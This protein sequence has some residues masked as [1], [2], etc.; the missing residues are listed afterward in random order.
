MWTLEKCKDVNKKFR[1]INSSTNS[2]SDKDKKIV[3][4]ITKTDFGCSNVKVRTLVSLL[5]DIPVE[6]FGGSSLTPYYPAGCVVVLL[7]D[8]TGY[9]RL[10]QGVILMR[11]EGKGYVDSAGNFHTRCSKWIYDNTRLATDEEVDRFFA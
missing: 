7:Q 11:W 10:K 2:M 4:F 8:K 6:S 3:E 1:N 5:T 9:Q